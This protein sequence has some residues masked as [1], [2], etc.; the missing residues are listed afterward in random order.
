MN[1]RITTT[2]LFDQEIK[3]LSKK[4]S[5]IKQDLTGLSL[6]LVKNPNLGTPIKFGCRKIRMAI[7]SKGKGKSGGARVITYYYLVQNTIYLL[8]IYDKSK[9]TNISDKELIELLKHIK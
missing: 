1:C 6:T 5:S 2:P 4:Y 8:A 7:K 9:Q 3:K